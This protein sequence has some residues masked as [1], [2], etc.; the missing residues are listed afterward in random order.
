MLL[1]IKNR[2]IKDAGDSPIVINMPMKN[3]H[4]ERLRTTPKSSPIVLASLRWQAA[5]PSV[6]MFHEACALKGETYISVRPL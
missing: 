4:K 2:Y 3:N 6:G 1:E 5:K